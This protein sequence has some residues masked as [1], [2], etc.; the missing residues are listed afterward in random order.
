MLTYE[1]A[2]GQKAAYGGDILFDPACSEH[3][4]HPIGKPTAGWPH[5]EKARCLK[6]GKVKDL[7]K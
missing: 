4:W 5:T 3:V 1:T 6:C 7:T 2:K